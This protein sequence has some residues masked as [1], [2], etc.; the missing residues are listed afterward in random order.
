MSKTQRK[1]VIIK[2]QGTPGLTAAVLGS[3][4]AILGIFTIG[5]LFIPFAALCT[6]IG[7]LRSATGLSGT[8]LAA[9]TIALVLTVMAA[10]MSPTF[11]I[12]MAALFA[13]SYPASEPGLQHGPAGGA[14][15]LLGATPLG[16]ATAK[17]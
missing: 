13:S 11:L 7:L 9:N 4:F 3:F 17:P 8:G 1:I 14:S 16:R 15:G 12:G 5:I 6:V 2:R 10:A